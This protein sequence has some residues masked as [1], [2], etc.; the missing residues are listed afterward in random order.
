MCV[1][2]LFAD[3]WLY[4]YRFCIFQA[5]NL[6]ISSN[7]LPSAPPPS[8][9]LVYRCVYPQPYLS[10]FFSPTLCRFLYSPRYPFG[11]RIVEKESNKDGRIRLRTI[12]LGRKIM[13]LFKGRKFSSTG[14]HRKSI[15][16]L[17]RP[18]CRPLH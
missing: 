9:V 6:S 5:D 18:Y 12:V 7:P 2:K 8:T 13:I 1:C 11:E 17:C 4:G 10:L 15:F 14:E 3:R 16:A